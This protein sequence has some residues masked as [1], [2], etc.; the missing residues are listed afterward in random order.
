VAIGTDLAQAARRQELVAVTLDRPRRRKRAPLL[1]G[2]ALVVILVV[3]MVMTSP[4][5]PGTPMV[6]V[7]GRRVRLAGEHPTVSQALR[8]AQVQVSPGAVRSVVTHRGIGVVP[9]GVVVD[10]HF[11]TLSTGLDDGDL[12][13]VWP[14]TDELE[15]VVQRAAVGAIAGLPDVERELWHPGRATDRPVSVGELSGEVVPDSVP[16]VAARPET[17][18]LVAL[19]FDD[20]PDPTWTPQVLQIL[21]DEGVPA[22]FCLVGTSLRRHPDLAAAERAQ[23]MTLCDHTVDHDVRL[24]RAPHDRVVAE[25]GQDAEMVR[26]AT[27]V[28]TRFYRPPGGTLS[29]D[30]ISVAHQRGMRVV[31]WTVDPSDYQRPPAPVLLGRILSKV[32]PGAIVLLHDGGGDRSQTVAMLK[33][34]IDALKAQGYG[35]TTPGLLGPVPAAAPAT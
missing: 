15:P 20:G 14:G 1:A 6:R 23:G 18:K 27:G 29:S 35:F 10:R 24:D 8:A 34:L 4:S 9:P 22:M 7:N 12:V 19:S 32:T 11:A 17:G 28:E 16:S 26:A 25:I 33:P 21:H 31:Y 5:S 2:A 13:E 30:I 3:A